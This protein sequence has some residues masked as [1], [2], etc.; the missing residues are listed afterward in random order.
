MNVNKVREAINGF[1]Q[2]H[3]AQAAQILACLTAKLDKDMNKHLY[4]WV[5]DSLDNVHDGL[6]EELVGE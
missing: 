2:I 3:P 1:H 4:G 5:I 6:V